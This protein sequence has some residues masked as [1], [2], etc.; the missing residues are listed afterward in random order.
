MKREEK[1]GVVAELQE[2]LQRAQ[3]AVLASPQG[4]TVGEM[5]ELRRDLRRVGGELK[6]AKNTL[7]RRAVAATP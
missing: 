4:L 6:V 7:A 5:S 1:T 3:M 2:R